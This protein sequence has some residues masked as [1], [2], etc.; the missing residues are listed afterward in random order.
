MCKNILP[1]CGGYDKCTL[2]PVAPAYM[3]PGGEVA[4][5]YLSCLVFKIRETE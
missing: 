3:V 2:F 5:E 1:L 4:E